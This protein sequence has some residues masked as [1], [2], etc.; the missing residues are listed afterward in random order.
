[1]PVR[2]ALTTKQIHDLKEEFLSLDQD[3]DGNI[4]IRELE[5][6]LRSMQNKLR[7]S[8]D[9]IQTAIK[10]L[11]MDGD[12]TINLA[13]FYKNQKNKTKHDLIHRALIQRSRIRKEF[14]KFDA[15]NS[16][17]IT[18]QEL[19]EVMHERGAKISA[20]QLTEMLSESDQDDDGKINY[21]EFVVLM[22]K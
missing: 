5:N 15:D 4:T 13:E 8:E 10:S 6:I 3:G 19:L 9:D 22:T 14:E 12:G 11:D 2:G 20:E 17:F 21:E 7:A 1:M 18:K 16:G